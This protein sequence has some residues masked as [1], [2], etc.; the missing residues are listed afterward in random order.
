MLTN[1]R[2]EGLLRCLPDVERPPTFSGPDTKDI[3]ASVI[4]T[5]NFFPEF[6]EAFLV[7]GFF[8]PAAQTGT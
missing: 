8:C 4:A 5:S 3:D 1:A 7:D 2:F 6:R